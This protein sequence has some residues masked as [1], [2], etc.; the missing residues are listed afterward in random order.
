MIS[1]AANRAREFR[2]LIRVARLRHVDIYVHWSVFLITAIMV[3]G[4]IRNPLVT[5]VGLASYLGMLIIHETGHLIVARLRGYDAL[6]IELYAISGKAYYERPESRFDRA[7]IAWGGVVAQAIIGVPIVLCTMVLGYSRFEAINVALGVLGG[8]SIL[9][10]AFNLLPFRT[11]DGAAAW[12]LVPAF[13]ERRRVRRARR[14]VP[15]RSPR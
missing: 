14:A 5:L 3:L 12:D 11:L 13:I 9:T 6:S 1:R 10:A 7:A 2:R 8:F 4:T 15:Y